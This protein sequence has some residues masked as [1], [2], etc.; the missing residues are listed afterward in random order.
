MSSTLY[1][2]HTYVYL[3][4]CVPMSKSTLQEQAMVYELTMYKMVIVGQKLMY[5]PD[6]SLH[7][8]LTLQSLLA[9]SILLA[10]YN[11][12]ILVK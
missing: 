7:P 4:V 9:S 10:F 1:V 12:I 5:R 3:T 6:A 2:V 11:C 8:A